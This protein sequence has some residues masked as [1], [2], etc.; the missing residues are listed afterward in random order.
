MVMPSPKSQTAHTIV[1]RMCDA[2]NETWDVIA[3]DILVAYGKKEIS[4]EL[5]IEAVL[6]ADRFKTYGGD[7][8]AFNTFNFLKKFEQE[9]VLRLAFP[10]E[11]YGY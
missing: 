2:L 1:Q 7:M 9:E 11:T 5:V 4:R 8:Q 10:H 3:S 6:D